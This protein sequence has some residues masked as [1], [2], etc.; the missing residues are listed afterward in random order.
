MYIIL[1]IL[2]TTG[3]TVL[4]TF[5]FIVS[6]ALERNEF[7]SCKLLRTLRLVVEIVRRCTL[8]SGK[9][10]DSFKFS[11][12]FLSDCVGSIKSE[13]KLNHTNLTIS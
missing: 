11:N 5:K 7:N 1:D 8:W 10:Y 3:N 9:R 13:E 4:V 2:G 12:S 6:R